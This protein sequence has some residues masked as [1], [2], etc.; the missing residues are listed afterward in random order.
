M[1]L[2]NTGGKKRK[3]LTKEEYKGLNAEELTLMFADGQMELVSQETEEI[4]I[5]PMGMP[6][7]SYN[8]VVRKKKD[9]GRVCIENVPPEEFLIAK[10]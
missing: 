4:G 6:I 9:V 8:V 2:S 10:R 7:L 5:D 1:V 3:I